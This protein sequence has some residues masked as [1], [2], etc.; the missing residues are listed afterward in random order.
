MRRPRPIRHDAGEPY[1][2]H[3]YVDGRFS[4]EEDHRVLARIG[5][6]HVP[7]RILE[8][9]DHRCP[10]EELVFNDHHCSMWTIRV[11]QSLGK[12]AKFVGCA[13]E[14]YASAS[15]TPRGASCGTWLPRCG[16]PVG[17]NCSVKRHAA[18]SFQHLEWHRTYPG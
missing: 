3:Q 11:H 5:L 6:K 13:K 16:S 8:R 9:S 7:T 4:G 1:I 14:L 17:E 18:L 2:R 10:D 15:P 12:K